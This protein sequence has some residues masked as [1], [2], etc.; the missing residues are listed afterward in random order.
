MIYRVGRGW[1]E[2]ELCVMGGGRGVRGNGGMAGQLGVM[3]IWLY[4]PT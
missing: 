3:V 1:L 4:A 2:E